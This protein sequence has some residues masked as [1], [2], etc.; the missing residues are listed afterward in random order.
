MYHL[1]THPVNE[2]FHCVTIHVGRKLFTGTFIGI[3]ILGGLLHRPSNIA[4]AMDVDGELSFCHIYIEHSVHNL[5]DWWPTWF[6]Y[7]CLHVLLSMFLVLQTTPNLQDIWRMILIPFGL[8]PGNSS[9]LL[10]C[11]WWCFWAGGVQ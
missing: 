10:F 2:W 6:I 4:Y 9:C 1:P 8:W 11:L 3:S 5:E 7:C